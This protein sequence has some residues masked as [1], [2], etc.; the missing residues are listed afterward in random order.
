MLTHQAGLKDW[1]PFWM[2]TVKKD[3][4]YKEGIYNTTPNDF[5]NKRVANDL[6]INKN[7]EDT[8]YKQITES[9]IKNAGK[10]LYSDLGYYYLKRII[11][12]ETQAAL[13]IY[14]QKTFYAPLGLST[15]TYKPLAKFDLDRIAPTEFDAKFRKQLVH[16]DV[17][18]QGAAMLGGVGGHA[19]LFSDAND[20]AVLMQMYMN[21]GEYGGMRYIDTA[22]ISEFTRCQ[23][24]KDNRR[25]IG[26]DKPEMN[27]EKESPVCSCV[28]YLSFGHAGF[29][30]TLA[31]ADPE[32]EL[33]YIFLSNR[34]YPDA[35]DNKLAKSGIRSKIQ[36][37]I[38]SSL[39]K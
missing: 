6:Y 2:K 27:P 39:K 31:W 17:H 21:K 3:G 23:Y 16:G 32:N 20:L 1:I 15:M 35:D 7:Y 34:V 10:Y 36:E 37:V 13:N 18:D 5:F 33:V 26:F 29:T 28:S 24:C 22:T 30:G 19:G 25:A 11:E 8:I 38:Y 12:K 4:T 14:V 9:P